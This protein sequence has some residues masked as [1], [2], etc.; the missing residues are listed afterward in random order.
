[1][2]VVMSGSDGHGMFFCEQIS[3][4]IFQMILLWFALLLYS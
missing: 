2:M 4:A 3:F 1:M